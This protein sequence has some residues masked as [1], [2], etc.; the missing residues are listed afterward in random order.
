MPSTYTLNNGIEL[1]GTGEQSGTWGDT[2]NTNL[3]LLDTALDGQ[4]TITATSAG[5]SSSPNDLPISD[6][7]ASNGRNRMIIITSATD[8]GTDVYY[9]LT[10]NDAEKIIYVRNDLNAQ[11]LI[12]FQGT[13]SASND[14]VV[15][16]GTTAVIYFNGGGSGAVA[17]N[18]FNN[19]YFD[20]LRLGSVSVTAIL[21]EDDMSSDSATSL[22]TQQSI[23]AYVDSQVTAQDLD[24][25]GDSGTGAVDLDSQTFTIAGT[26]NEIE[27]SASG[28]TLTVGLPSA[29]TVT[30]SVTTATVTGTTAV[31]T[32][33]IN[34]N[35]AG[36]GVTIDSVLLKDDV[37]NATD[38]ETTTISANDGT[39]AITISNTSANVNFDGGVSMDQALT[40]K[41]NFALDGSTGTGTDAKAIEVGA[42]RTGDGASYVD[43]IGDATYTDF[44]ARFLRSAGAN[45]STQLVHRGTGTFQMVMSDANSGFRFNSSSVV[46]DFQVSTP[47]SSNLI[48]ADGDTDR[49]GI[50]TASP[51]ATFSVQGSS[52]VQN[53]SNTIVVSG[54][55]TNG[56]GLFKVF[57]TSANAIFR[58]DAE[59]GRVGINNDSPNTELQI[60]STGNS[61]A[62]S[63]V[64]N[65]GGTAVFEVGVGSPAANANDGYLK[66]RNQSN[67]ESIV[68]N[69]DGLTT[70][71]KNGDS[72][73]DFR[74]TSANHTNALFV[75]SNTDRVGINTAGPQ[76]LFH[77]QE[78]TALGGTLNDYSRLQRWQQETGNEQI[79]DA[80]AFRSAAGSDWTT[81][82]IRLQSIVDS[83]YQAYVQWN[84]S[85]TPAGLTIGTG[86]STSGYQG[87]TERVRF[88]QNT[89]GVDF[90]NPN[91]D[92]NF[93][94][95]TANQT[96]LY[97]DGG[98][99]Y[100]SMG[101]TTNQGGM[102]TVDGFIVPGDDGST[103]GTKLL[104]G[105][106]TG[107][108]SHISTWGGMA[109]D[110]GPMMGYGVWPKPSVSEA[111]VSS[112]GVS[113]L[114]RSAFHCDG[115]IHRWY[116]GSAQTVA[117]DSDVTMSVAA[118]LDADGLKFGTDTAADNALDDYEQGTWTA[119]YVGSSTAG[120]SPTA[121]QATY[122][123]VGNI[124][125]ATCAF[126]NATASGAAGNM[127]ITGLP[128]AANSA[129]NGEHF[130]AAAQTGLGG[131]VLGGSVINGES[132]IRMRDVLTTVYEPVVN[133]SGFY[134]FITMTYTAV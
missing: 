124:V 121:T 127:Y 4:V 58:V 35:S 12:L 59:L 26:T 74:V 32:D 52:V 62:V 99:D 91:E 120:S 8:L 40:I 116:V 123:R 86:G 125:V 33:T 17:A 71:N 133:T 29:V 82:G 66:L 131:D 107:S 60:T 51:A 85:G 54:G 126:K 112:T 109:S 24:F 101:T 81:Q 108:T 1:I 47:N 14:Y 19:A 42:G 69:T 100:V 27:T 119:T 28:Q 22:A 105:R 36:S 23:K 44:G 41:G 115:N 45:G 13:Y 43:L 20:S 79:L 118:S 61:K 34:E 73:G 130:A 39:T 97:I 18:V 129:S 106:Y 37:V 38:I 3:E 80:V 64:Y 31:K 134:L 6:G 75:D 5:S 76:G 25:G 114:K 78:T 84:G 49:V 94:V 57:N 50:N 102:L 10:P 16:N 70:F 87:A 117:T 113:S 92:Y 93:T 98:S 111:F 46:A 2:T 21:D 122:T 104:A 88:Y 15:P 56:H 55:T 7:A 95:R 72:G 68:L 103:S 110:G 89:V 30:T 128:Y 83:T 48:L 132:R 9:Q 63:T 90:N 67:Q 11:D 96:S 53:T 77:I 65:S